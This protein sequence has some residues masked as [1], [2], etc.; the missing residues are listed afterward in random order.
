MMA[1][2]KTWSWKWGLPQIKKI[3]SAQGY[4]IG[5]SESQLISTTSAKLEIKPAGK[6][7]LTTKKRIIGNFLKL[8]LIT[9]AMES[10]MVNAFDDN[11]S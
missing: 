11:L 6:K 1:V 7:E 3:L 5:S 2:S 8:W 4:Y 10:K 9:P